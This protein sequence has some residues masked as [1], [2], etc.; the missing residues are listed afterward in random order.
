[1]AAGE[2]DAGDAYSVALDTWLALGGADLDARIGKAWDELGLNVALLERPMSVLSGGEAA[3]AGLAALILSRFDVY[4]L[5]EPTNDLDLDGLA[6]LE[7]FVTSISGSV[8][9]VSHDR[10]FLAQFD[11]YIMITDDGEVYA[12]PDFDIAMAGLS[13]PDKLA[14]LRLAKPLTRD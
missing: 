1:M 3:R 9:L 6:R 4:L 2:D 10:T 8:V 5:D 11:R 7:N 12:L 13:E 14:G